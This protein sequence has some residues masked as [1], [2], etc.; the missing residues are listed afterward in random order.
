[1]AIRNSRD[2]CE[3]ML[4]TYKQDNWHLKDTV[5]P[6]QTVC[7][8]AEWEYKR[9][10]RGKACIV[11]SALGRGNIHMSSVMCM[12]VYLFSGKMRIVDSKG[13]VKVSP[14]EF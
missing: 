14:C 12:C 4:R 1:M 9:Q 6:E 3:Q 7:A 11:K 13:C 5:C 10:E 2:H 8:G